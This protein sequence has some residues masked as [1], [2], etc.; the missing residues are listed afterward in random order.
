MWLLP[1]LQI[2]D[3]ADAGLDDLQLSNQPGT[4]LGGGFA[5][6]RHTWGLQLLSQ[7]GGALLPRPH[8]EGGR[9]ASSGSTPGRGR[10]RGFRMFGG[11]WK[12]GG[13]RRKWLGSGRKR[14][15][16]EKGRRGEI[17]K[18]MRR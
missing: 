4:Q 2:I 13:G 10:S 7:G 15:G 17:G 11:G 16:L 14:R 5:L 9:T 1:D 3:E 8:F 6:V 12:R 18:I